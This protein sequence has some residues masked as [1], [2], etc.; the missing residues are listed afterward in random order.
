MKAG[1]SRLLLVSVIAFASLLGACSPSF[2]ANPTPGAIPRVGLMHVGTD[3]LPPSLGTLVG[4]LADLGWIDGSHDELV[5]RLV[6]DGHVEGPRGTEMTGA[7]CLSSGLLSL[8][9]YSREP[10]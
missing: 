10:R 4:R 1:P 3:H 6:H 2:G 8:A 5:A 7:I 9:N